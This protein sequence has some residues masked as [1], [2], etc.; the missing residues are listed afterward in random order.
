VA[1]LCV[2]IFLQVG[3][4][5][6]T[7]TVRSAPPIIHDSYTY[8]AKAEQLRRCLFQ[9]CPAMDDLQRQSAPSADASLEITHQRWLQHH[10]LIYQYHPLHALAVAALREAGL[11]FHKALAVLGVGGALLIAA[12]VAYF[13]YASWGW[14]AAACGL[15]LL[16]TAVYPGYHGTHWIVP[17][18]IALGIGL[19]AWAAL[20]D[21]RRWGEIL[22]PFFVLAML[23][24]HPAG[25]IYA[26]VA[27]ILHA[28]L[29]ARQSRRS[30]PWLGA[31]ALVAAVSIAVPVLTGAPALRHEPPVP[32][33]GWTVWHGIEINFLAALWVLGQWMDGPASLA[34]VALA[35]VGLTSAPPSRRR[36]VYL[37]TGLLAAIAVASL[38]Y[39]LARYPAEVFHR[40]VVP[41][42]VICGGAA[43]H[44][45]W[46][47]FAAFSRPGGPET[48]PWRWPY[49]KV[50]GRFAGV[51]LGAVLLLGGIW[52][53][54]VLGGEALW[55]KAKLIIDISDIE[56]DVSQPDRVLGRLSVDDRL[57]YT[58]ELALYFYLSNGALGHGA[59]YAPAIHSATSR[60]AEAEWLTT[61]RYAVSAYPGFFAQVDLRE[62]APL[63]LHFDREPLPQR[64]ALLIDNN[65]D[66]T[67]IVLRDKS[68]AEEVRV[69]VAAKSADWIDLALPP[70][71]IDSQLFI[72]TTGGG[73][74]LVL[75]GLKLDPGQSLHWPWD[76]GVTLTYR[77][78]RPTFRGYSPE[79]TTVSVQIASGS[80]IPPSCTS[81]GV[82]EDGGATAAIRVSCAA[83]P[84]ILDD[85]VDGGL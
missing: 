16:S 61:V 81:L 24:M 52:D 69:K 57:A 9:D 64:I 68:G 40:V 71:F 6:A 82:L 20:V 25:R 3:V 37:L 48:G 26:V 14:G 11:S 72:E 78:H 15:F 76:E 29:F 36:T 77:L 27:L 8:I 34:V 17:S 46:S 47:W 55:D 67:S 43:G 31:A 75:R 35:A 7:F 41:L 79:A 18:N 4:I 45:A 70:F 2:Y 65:G 21:R 63:E 56:L 58:D 23:W 73:D 66:A 51:A 12:G 62:N 1:G 13:L 38:L 80:L 19:L 60:A 30:W 50:G 44:G 5:V 74:S 59:Y 49:P 10:R 39:P 85:A 54:A 83:S 28:V 32:P 33:E 22:L 42:A 84:E 53:R